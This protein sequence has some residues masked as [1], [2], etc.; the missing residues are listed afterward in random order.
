[1]SEAADRDRL[2][3]LSLDEPI[4]DRF[5]SVAPLVVVGTTEPDGSND[6][7]PKHLAGPA[8]WGNLFGFVC[9]PA[10][11]TYR[12]IVREEVFTVSYLRPGQI[13]QASLASAPRDDEGDKPA[14]AAL[15]TRS[16]EAV[17]GVVLEGCA[18]YLECRL[19]RIIDDLDENSMIIGRIVTARVDR[20]ALRDPDRDDAD[21]LAASPLLAF[22]SPDHFAT[23][24]GGLHFPFHA[25]WRR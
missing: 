9:S 21:V 20:E 10:H 18:V 3:D 14:L 4:W 11:A 6:L 2:V 1:M 16:A 24:R 13:V 12:N 8:S 19:E 22:L 23:V 15:L 5:F 7:A 17:P 25:G